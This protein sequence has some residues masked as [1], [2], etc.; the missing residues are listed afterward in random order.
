[1]KI[2]L[3]AS[4]SFAATGL[5]DQLRAARHEV[6]TFNRSALPQAGSRDLAGAYDK[7]GDIAHAEMQEC[8]V[9]INYAIVKNGTIEQNIRMTDLIME[10]AR[11]LGVKRFIHISSI[12]VLPSITG[13]V[14]E[15]VSAVDAK[16]KGSYSRVK[17]AVE[18]HIIAQ[19][20][21]GELDIVRPGFILAEGLV[22]SMVGTGMKLPT[23][24]VLGL[25]N[26]KTVIMLIHRDTV[27][28]ALTKI[29]SAPLPDA[30]KMK[31]F[32]LVAPNAPTREE[33]LGFQCRELGRGWS[34]IHFPSWLWRLALACGSVPLSLLKRK[35]FR[36]VKLF[37]HNL[38][39]RQYNCTKTQ[40]A[41]NLD[42]NFDWQKTLRDLEHVQPSPAWPCGTESCAMV[43]SLAY[44]GMG[45][46]VKQKHLPGLARNDFAGRISWSDPAL[47]E[48]PVQPGLN[49]EAQSGIAADATHAVITAP[50]V[51]R[52][53]I[54]SS[55]PT[56]VT[57]VLVEKPFAVSRVQLL[58]FK[59]LLA[60]RRVSVLHNYRLK[61]NVIRFREFL[62][63]HPS[64]A[65]RGVTLHYETP[66]PALEQ[67]SWMRQERQHRILLTDYSMHYLDLAWLFCEGPMN[68]HRCTTNFNDRDELE[69]LSAALSFNGVPCDVLIRQGCH[70]RQCIITHLF[71][72]YTTQL[73]FFPD[74]FVPMTGGQ[75][76][77]DD[78]KLSAAGMKSTL[79]KVGEKLGICVADH[80][81]DLVLESF[82]GTNGALRLK[83]FSLEELL[84]F[85]ERLTELADMVYG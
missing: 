59:R 25:G 39:V 82:T 36:L 3:L 5:L 12:S 85:Y 53:K 32:M 28:E 30:P 67:S 18:Q 15:D 55:L 33:Y 76:M 73:R 81:H 74:V 58:E 7:L 62:T 19:W 50:W 84:P 6:W 63:A 68:V 83:E 54:F 31:P 38:N 47:S 40:Q 13:T 1:M 17:A 77:L 24:Q 64:G 45:R 29:A 27:N 22:D 35:Q 66:S 79:L 71:Q 44:F 41:L 72:N 37:E 10:A 16:W 34:T 46:I 51:T 43:K 42:M 9:L 70:Q 69:T 20:K 4:S 57:D 52:S 80:S 78:A 60:G 8:D 26:R 61:P 23:G 48:A 11:R 14:D 2:L 65:L 21:T 75:N 49:I 56:S